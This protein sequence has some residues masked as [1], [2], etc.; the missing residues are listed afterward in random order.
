MS[1]E[2][3]A[4]PCGELVVSCLQTRG[5]VDQLSPQCVPP[6]ILGLLYLAVAVAFDDHLQLEWA[7]ALLGCL[8]GEI[9]GASVVLLV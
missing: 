5:W 2:D 4:L 9:G 6:T 8:S 7:V 3:P 1:W